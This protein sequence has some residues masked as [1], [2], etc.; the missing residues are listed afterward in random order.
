MAILGFRP[1]MPGEFFLAKHK[2]A[3]I[4]QMK[5]NSKYKDTLFSQT[6]EIQENKVP[7]SLGLRGQ[8]D[9]IRPL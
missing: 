5:S 8:T 3:Q 2:M 6:I 1:E 4:P 9:Q 7:L